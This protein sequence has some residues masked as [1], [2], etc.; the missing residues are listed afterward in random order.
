[1]ETF[2]FSECGVLIQTGGSGDGFDTHKY[3][4]SFSVQRGHP[5][6]ILFFVKSFKIS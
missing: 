1:M 6:Q 4:I 5:S 2:D 3:F